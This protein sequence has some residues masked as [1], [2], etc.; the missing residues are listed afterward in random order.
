MQVMSAN[1][2]FNDFLSQISFTYA[3]N[4]LSINS[5]WIEIE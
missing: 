3:S 1:H 2:T 5:V 4:Y